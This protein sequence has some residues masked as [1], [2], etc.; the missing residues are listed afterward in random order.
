MGKK[1]KKA[2]IAATKPGKPSAQS[3]APAKPL[4][5]LERAQKCRH[6]LPTEELRF[7]DK[8]S[9]FMPPCDPRQQGVREQQAQAELI[10]QAQDVLSQYNMCILHGA[11]SPDEVATVHEEYA[12]L[13]DFSSSS[14]VGEKNARLRSGTRFFNCQ[15]QVGPN[16]GFEGWRIGSERTKSICDLDHVCGEPYHMCFHPKSSITTYC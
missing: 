11:L 12:G 9:L 6:G 5:D 1:G 8:V 3:N 14:A 15:C 16:C 13:L 4:T 7:L 2:A 10:R